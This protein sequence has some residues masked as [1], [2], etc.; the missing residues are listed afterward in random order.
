MQALG[1]AVQQTGSF[2]CDWTN[3]KNEVRELTILDKRLEG[4]LLSC[5]RLSVDF[6][7]QA[8]WT[9]LLADFSAFT[10]SCNLTTTAVLPKFFTRSVVPDHLPL[11][12]NIFV[13]VPNTLSTKPDD[14]VAYA[15]TQFRQSLERDPDWKSSSFADAQ[16]RR[17]IKEQNACLE[18]AANR[19]ASDH[20]R[21]YQKKANAD[22]SAGKYLTTAYQYE[23]ERKA[24]EAVNSALHNGTTREHF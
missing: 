19:L 4:L 21:S 23:Q 12:P 10:A 18:A 24:I 15:L 8:S 1:P 7:D 22:F 14:G 20:G 5:N 9:A 13:E 6:K 11:D 16:I 17:R 3:D 2:L